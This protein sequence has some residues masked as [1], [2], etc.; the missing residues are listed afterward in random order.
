MTSRLKDR[1][2]L[3]TILI[4]LVSIY[5]TLA[6]YL[7]YF[8][9]GFF[10]GQYRF[11][12]WLGWVGVLFVAIYTPTYYILKRRTKVSVKALLGIHVIGNLT[13]IS[14]V[15]VHFAHQISRSPQ[16]YPDLGTGILLELIMLIMLTT[17]IFQRFRIVTSQGRKWRFIHASV[18]ISFYLVIFIHILHG[19]GVI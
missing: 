2:F 14:L 16:Y 6:T 12:H 19:I 4:I 8:S 9:L 5:F 17:G 11:N 1:Y 7:R 3:I 15:S 18:A 13:A 10:V